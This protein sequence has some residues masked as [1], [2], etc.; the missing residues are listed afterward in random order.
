MG[1]FTEANLRDWIANN[2]KDLP[3]NIHGIQECIDSADESLSKNKSPIRDKDIFY[4]INESVNRVLLRRAVNALRA[5]K[6]GGGLICLGTEFPLLTTT[7]PGPKPSADILA[8]FDSMATYAIF[9][10]KI[11]ADTA[12]ECITELSAYAN[13]LGQQYFGLSSMDCLWII[14]STEYRPTVMNAIAHHSLFSGKCILPIL[15]KVD[16]REGTGITDVSF[17]I[18]EIHRPIPP[19]LTDVIFWSGSYELLTAY[20][21]EPHFDNSLVQHML[22]NDF[23]SMG[24]SGFCFNVKTATSASSQMTHPSGIVMAHFNPFKARLKSQELKELVERRR[25]VVGSL[26]YYGVLRGDDAT[27]FADVDLRKGKETIWRAA[28]DDDIDDDCWDEEYEYSLREIGDRPLNSGYFAFKRVL[29][30][31]NSSSVG[32]TEVTCPDFHGALLVKHFLNATH[33][34]EENMRN[35]RYFGLLH[36]IIMEL[37]PL[38]SGLEKFTER[39]MLELYDS[40]DFILYILRTVNFPWRRV[41]CY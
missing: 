25:I 23:T 8:I 41:D 17:S 36:D 29:D 9:E 34:D 35:I 27:E 21:D 5:L 31:I 24:C 28:D 37:I 30:R 12:R 40:P 2:I 7:L 32:G 26:D 1:G 11:S 38:L 14:I 4:L 22:T 13:G 3:F 6:A 18:E 10:I 15:A 16:Y 19:E 20:S 33:Y 39:S